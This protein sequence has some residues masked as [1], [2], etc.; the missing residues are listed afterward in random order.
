MYIVRVKQLILLTFQLGSGAPPGLGEVSLPTPVS[1]GG[2]SKHQGGWLSEEDAKA[3]VPLAEAMIE[4]CK[5]NH[6]NPTSDG[7]FTVGCAALATSTATS[8]AASFL[9]LDNPE[10]Q[11]TDPHCEY[12]YSRMLFGTFT[13][14]PAALATS[15]QQAVRPSSWN[16]IIH[17][18]MASTTTSGCCS[19]VRTSTATRCQYACPRTLLQEH[20]VQTLRS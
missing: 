14:A 17:I 16:S 5:A 8:S 6:R 19:T 18:L 7:T 12:D 10:C 20:V 3:H 9:E 4:Y 2:A 15:W 11:C 1:H 13:A